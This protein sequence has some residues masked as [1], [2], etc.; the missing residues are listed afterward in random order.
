MLFANLM[1][2]GDL[3]R[4]IRCTCWTRRD[5]IEAE[6]RGAATGDSISRASPVLSFV[7]GQAA[8]GTIVLRYPEYRSKRIAHAK[9]RSELLEDSTGRIMRCGNDLLSRKRRKIV[10][11][12]HPEDHLRN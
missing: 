9:Q 2:V 5:E 7:A 12:F 6:T 8:D 3:R 4:R 1:K 10:P 11:E